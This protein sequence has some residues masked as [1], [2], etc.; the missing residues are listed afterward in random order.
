M[1]Q[2]I[3]ISIVFP[4]FNDSHS[5][6]LLI[7]HAFNVAKKLSN[8]YEII[9]IDDGS[10]DASRTILK[11]LTKKYSK[12]HLI[13]HKKNIGY[14]GALRSGFEKASK[15]FVFYTDGDGQYD[16]RELPLLFNALTPDI[17]FV[18]GIKTV[19]HDPTHRI[20]LGNIYSFFARWAFWLPVQDVDCDFRLI[21]KNILKKIHLQCTS[22]AVCVELV[23]KAQ[24][25]GAVFAQI[26][27]HHYERKYGVSQ[28]FRVNR[29]L[30][31][32][33]EIAFLWMQL[34]IIDPLR[35][36]RYGKPKV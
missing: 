8:D 20:V 35:D 10:T 11:K 25:Q 26:S 33:R 32:L 2:K 18:N 36:S 22:G 19:R 4:C 34:M 23:K 1:K 12:L 29:L 21:K 5:I 14:G 9:V 27:V 24:R 15:Q 7:K 6:G 31:T 3:S 30:S 16:V 28:F 13:F 17:S